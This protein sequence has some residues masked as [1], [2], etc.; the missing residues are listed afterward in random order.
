MLYIQ[1][2]YFYIPYGVN[3]TLCVI[4]DA[5]ALPQALRFPSLVNVIPV[6]STFSVNQCNKY[7]NIDWLH[8]YVNSDGWQMC[9]GTKETAV[10]DSCL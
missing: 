7:Q 3:I 8:H 9:S 5:Q 2:L 10:A 4:Y 1:P 6:G